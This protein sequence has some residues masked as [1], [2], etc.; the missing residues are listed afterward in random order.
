[1]DFFFLGMLSATN[2]SG[3]VR[4]RTRKTSTAPYFRTH[5]EHFYPIY[6]N[7]NHWFSEPCILYILVYSFNLLFFCV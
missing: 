5:C 4:A 1:M 6:L 2:N 7:Y 3:F